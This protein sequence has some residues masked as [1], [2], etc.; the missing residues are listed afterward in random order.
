MSVEPLECAACGEFVK[1]WAKVT[2]TAGNFDRRV[3][4]ELACFGSRSLLVEADGNLLAEEVRYREPWP[5][6]IARAFLGSAE[7]EMAK[8]YAE[9]TKAVE[10]AWYGEDAEDA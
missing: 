5:G 8:V 4:L 6:E 9:M 1:L 7:F 3:R 10:I 2:R